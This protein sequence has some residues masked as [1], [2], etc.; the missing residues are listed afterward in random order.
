MRKFLSLTATA[1]VA[2]LALAA[3]S[4][5]GTS[6]PEEDTTTPESGAAAEGFDVTTIE[7]V[8]DIAAMVPDTLV[9]SASSLVSQPSSFPSSLIFQT[10]MHRGSG[11]WRSSCSPSSSG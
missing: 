2:A 3:C 11:C 10:W 5:P 9:T 4:D 8:A 1:A 6:A 7:P